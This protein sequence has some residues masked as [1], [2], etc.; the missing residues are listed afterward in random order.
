MA[1]TRQKSIATFVTI[2]VVLI[3]IAVALN[4]SWIVLHWRRVGL[5]IVGV[6]FFGLIIAG[7]IVNVVFLVREIRRN[8]QHDSFINAVTHELKT[9]IASLRLYLETLK[10]RNVE[11]A[12]RQEFYDIMLADTA[13]LL[14]TVEQVL[15]AGRTGQKGR[16]LTRM[17]IDLAEVAEESLALARQQ[18]HLS[19]ELQLSLNLPRNGMDPE[20]TKVMGDPE[21]LRA[22]ISNLIDNAVKY[23]GES[24]RVVVEV[25]P[26]DKSVFVRVRDNGIGL[27]PEELKH[28]FKRFYRV[29][30]KFMARVKA[31]GL[32]LF[33]VQSVIEKHGGKVEVSSAGPNQGSTFTIR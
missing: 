25:E 21:E 11:E 8:E 17:E 6:I 33:I 23:S 16:S 22:A 26:G 24:V 19:S 20:S 28:V 3:A 18:Y 12:Q 5:V 9:P 32:G 1:S 14:H 4:I 30:G 13:R 7:M 10:K 29:P 15:R 31:T 27:A 2:S